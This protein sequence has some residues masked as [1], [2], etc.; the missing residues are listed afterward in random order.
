MTAAELNA[1]V[2]ERLGARDE[3]QPLE[4][5]K[6]TAVECASVIA[7]GDEEA[8]QASDAAAGLDAVLSASDEP[9]E[10]L[11]AILFPIVEYGGSAALPAI[12]RSLLHIARETSML[13][14]EQTTSRRGGVVVVGRL[15]WASSA[16]A[17]H[18]D[19]PHAI[20]AARRASG[21]SP[22]ENG[23]IRILSSHHLRY[24]EALDGSARSS[25][26][27]Y[28]DWL[29]GRELVR[30]GYPMFNA[31]VHGLV[32]EADLLLALCMASERNGV[33]SEGLERDT[34]ERLRGRFLDATQ[35]R[36]LAE[37]FG[38][39]ESELEATAEGLYAK[40]RRNEQRLESPPARLFADVS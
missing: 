31:D 4:A 18:C 29:A 10:R 24:P 35:R 12:P 33:Y 1:E 17:L 2:L 25:Y 13:R 9:N 38:V 3:V 19:R 26:A 8:A 40:L 14:L 16:Y 6:R 37:L 5:L 21:R 39:E 23:F 36:E 32:A 30:E 20:A 22:F 28:R 15:I 7:A 27:H 11:L 34:V